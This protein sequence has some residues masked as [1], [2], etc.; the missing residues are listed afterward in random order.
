MVKLDDDIKGHEIIIGHTN[1]PKEVQP[2]KEMIKK[3]FGDDLEINVVWVNPTAGSHCGPNNVGV[4]FHAI[5]R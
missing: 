4:A 3:Q 1:A 2:L 5:H